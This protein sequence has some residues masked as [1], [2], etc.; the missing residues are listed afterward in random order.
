MSVSY[1]NSE[2]TCAFRTVSSKLRSRPRRS[3]EI[4]STVD[5]PLKAAT[6]STMLAPPN[7]SRELRP[8]PSCR[9]HKSAIWL[10]RM[11]AFVHQ[12]ASLRRFAPEAATSCS[13]RVRDGHQMSA[14]SSEADNLAAGRDVSQRRYLNRPDMGRAQS[15][16]YRP[17]PRTCL[18][19][20]NHTPQP[21]ER[22]RFAQLVSARM[23][24][25]TR[26]PDTT[27]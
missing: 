25:C 18:C 23:S 22:R 21:K 12:A 9:Q 4:V 7:T 15:Q 13:P 8:K 16:S 17:R 5:T 27:D 6:Q 20:H 14:S 1:S 3:L 11:N 2:T 19:P 10:G 26:R 24:Y